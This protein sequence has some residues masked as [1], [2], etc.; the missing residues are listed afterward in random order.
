MGHN[1]PE[2]RS[3][4]KLGTG[5][6]CSVHNRRGAG[7][8]YVH[9]S[10]HWNPYGRFLPQTL[11]RR[12]REIGRLMLMPKILALIAMQRQIAASRS[13]SP[14]MREQHG[15]TLVEPIVRPSNPPSTSAH[16]PSWS[17]FL[18]HV[19]PVGGLGICGVGGLGPVG[20]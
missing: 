17:A 11:R 6:N 15:S 2:Y 13:I 8:Q 18:G 20:G 14:S 7:F 4:E 19:K 5:G 3:S 12:V 10:G 16:T 1:L 9:L